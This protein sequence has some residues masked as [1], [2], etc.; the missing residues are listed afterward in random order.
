MVRK[1]NF[2]VVTLMLIL[3]MSACAGT[4]APVVEET[5]STTDLSGIK[6]YL[7]DKT[8]ELTASS[9]ALKAA[10]DKYYEL[11]NAAGFD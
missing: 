8:S 2:F 9:G 10:S 6:T 4:Q 1:T 7:L 11:A 5:A 3:L